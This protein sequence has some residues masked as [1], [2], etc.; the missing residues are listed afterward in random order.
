MNTSMKLV[1]AC[2]GKRSTTDTHYADAI[3]AEA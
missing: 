3:R 1:A 2:W